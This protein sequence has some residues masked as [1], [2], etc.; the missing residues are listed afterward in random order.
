MKM[1]WMKVVWSMLLFIFW[2][3]QVVFWYFLFIEL[4]I[5]DCLFKSYVLL[6][7]AHKNVTFLKN[8]VRVALQYSF[9]FCCTR[10]KISSIYTYPLALE[11]LSNSLP[12]HPSRA[13][14]GTELSSLSYSFPLACILHMV[15][16][17]YQHYCPNTSHPP[18]PLCVYMYILYSCFASRLTCIIFLDST[19]IH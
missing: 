10:K 18:I 4:K 12:S 3:F 15:V 9:S 17:I 6:N 8:W 2:L 5:V 7:M 11:P 16:Y 19:Y 13:T 14:R 1:Q